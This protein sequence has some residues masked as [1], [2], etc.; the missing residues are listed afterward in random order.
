MSIVGVLVDDILVIDQWMS[1]R[2]LNGLICIDWD[3]YMTRLKVRRDIQTGGSKQVVWKF[4]SL[5]AVCTDAT[6]G[7]TQTTKMWLR[8]QVMNQS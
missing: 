4:L 3:I 8:H 5:S 7:F 6:C 1:P 2:R